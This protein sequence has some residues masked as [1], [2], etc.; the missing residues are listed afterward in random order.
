MDYS[1]KI[2]DW[3]YGEKAMKQVNLLIEQC[4]LL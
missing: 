2:K 1:E 3:I 4:K